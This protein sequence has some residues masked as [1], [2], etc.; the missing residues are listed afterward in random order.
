MRLFV[1]LLFICV[2]ITVFW[3][4]D[5]DSGRWELARRFSRSRVNTWTLPL[6]ILILAQLF[7]CP[8]LLCW[9]FGRT[10]MMVLLL[11]PGMVLVYV[12]LYLVRRRFK[13]FTNELLRSNYRV[14][15]ECLYSLDAIAESG[16]CPECGATFTPESL[17]AKWQSI[18]LRRTPRLIAP[19]AARP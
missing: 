2:V 11:V 5:R 1:V 6:G 17:V 12:H 4:R 13:E 9:Y 3:K 16:K 15:P 14:C 19:K 7:N 8:A 10:D 18:C